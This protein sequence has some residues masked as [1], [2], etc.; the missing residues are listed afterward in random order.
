MCQLV[1][2][3]VFDFR[4][5]SKHFALSAQRIEEAKAAVEVDAF[6]NIISHDRP[7]QIAL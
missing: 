6:E 5:G 1:T 3:N 2:L 4:N 7:K